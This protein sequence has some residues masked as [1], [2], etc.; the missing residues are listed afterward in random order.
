ML[1]LKKKQKLKSWF[2]L[3]SCLDI[4]VIEICVSEITLLS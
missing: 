3:A 4:H 2:S 1:P